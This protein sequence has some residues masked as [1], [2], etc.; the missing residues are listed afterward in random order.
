[1]NN[2]EIERK[3]LVK[4]DFW[5][6]LVQESFIIK[7]G[8]FPGDGRIVTSRVRLSGKKAFLTIKGP[9]VGLSR[10]EFEYEIPSKDAIQMLDEYCK[11]EK[12][13]KVRSLVRCGNHLWEIDEFE[14]E[15]YPLVIA[16]VELKSE[17]EVFEFPDWLGNEVTRDARYLNVNLIQNPYSAWK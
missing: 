8:Y 13:E 14:G 15:N 4:S 9:S 5:K 11:K 16:E 10:S 12:I 6:G 7:Q 1:M 17:D 3:F 2:V